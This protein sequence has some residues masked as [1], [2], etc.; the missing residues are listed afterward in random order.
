MTVGIVKIVGIVFIMASEIMIGYL[1]R[2]SEKKE[3]L[4][5]VQKGHNYGICSCGRS[6]HMKSDD[7]IKN[8]T[9]TLREGTKGNHK[10]SPRQNPQRK[11]IA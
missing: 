5:M 4:F 11:P 6:C 8:T 1:K 7:R 9:K 3:A 10:G 2:S